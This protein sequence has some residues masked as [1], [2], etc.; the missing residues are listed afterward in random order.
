M[1]DFRDALVAIANA[2]A[3]VQ[4]VTGRTTKN[5]VAWARIGDLPDEGIGY[6][7][8]AEVDTPQS[9]RQKL[10]AVSFACFGK[11]LER[12]ETLVDRVQS[13]GASGMFIHANFQAEGVDACPVGLA[14]ARD[15]SD[16]EQD[17]GRK[18]HRI[19]IDIQFEVKYQ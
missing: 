9:G 10:V 19:D 6:Q 17:D 2:D 4:A 14:E 1:K 11:T 18:E 12:A 7:I 16:L 5:L 13:E 8:L 3:G 15:M